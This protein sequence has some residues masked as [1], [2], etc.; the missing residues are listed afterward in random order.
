MVVTG[1]GLVCASGIGTAEVW[2]N[3]LA[4]KCGIRGITRFDAAAF[5][6]RIAGEVA[7]FDPLR[8]VEKKELKKMGRFIQLAIAAADDAMAMAGLK[9]RR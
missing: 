8:W 5:D 6:C 3:L 4:G 7:E 2:P 1:V 9:P